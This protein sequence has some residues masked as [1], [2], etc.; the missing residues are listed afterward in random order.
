MAGVQG[1]RLAAAVTQAGGLGSIPCAMLNED[2][3]ITA[4]NDVRQHTEGALNLNFFCHQP[5]AMD[6][7]LRLFAASLAPYFEEYD[8]DP[9]DLDAGAGRQPFNEALAEL[10]RG[11]KPPVVSF[12]FGLPAASLL[13]TVRESGA[14]VISSATTVEEAVWLEAHGVDAV[15]VQGV[16]AGGHRGHFLNRDLSGQQSTLELLPAV[17]AVV[18]CPLIAAGGISR[19]EQARDAMHRGADAVQIGTAYLLCP[20]ADTSALHRSA[21]RGKQAET[22]LTNVFTGRPARGLINRLMREMGPMNDEV[23]DFPLASGLVTQLRRAAEEKG[24]DEFSPLWAGT[25]YA[26]IEEVSAADVTR[27]MAL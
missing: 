26:D 4:V 9:P 24:A 1:A 27:R 15:I 6:D 19:P 11:L 17:A 20:E 7:R 25:G 14:L 12:H 5:P 10:V 18:Q 22:A 2:Q 13:E 3:I 8:L 16:E 21:L 23:P